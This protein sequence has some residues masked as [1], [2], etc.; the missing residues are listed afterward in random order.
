LRVDH[1]SSL[2]RSIARLDRDSYEARGAV[3]DRALRAL[4]KRIAVADPPYSQA[5]VDMEI[6]N[7]R[8]AI[9]RIE[10]GDMDD[11]ASL[12]PEYQPAPELSYLPAPVRLADAEPIQHELDPS[13][14]EEIAGK[15]RSIFGRVAGRSIIAALLIGAVIAGYSHVT[16][17]IDLSSL[18]GLMDRV[19]AINWSLSGDSA[20][21]GGLWRTDSMEVTQSAELLESAGGEPRGQP[22]AGKAVWRVLTDETGDTVLAL[23]VEIP[24]RGF[25]MAMTLRRDETVGAAMSHLCEI[26]FRGSDQFPVADI[27]QIVGVRMKNVGERNG[28]VLVGQV[29]RIAPDAFLF[30]LSALP[31]DMR[32]NIAAIR[33]RSRLELLVSLTDN[34]T[35]MLVVDKGESGARAFAEAF[36]KWGQ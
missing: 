17:Q 21:P 4:E 12:V 28:D 18:F 31:N 32:H 26:Q 6:L 10:F 9:R 19:T 23:D 36:N 8:D 33:G 16:G 22:S 7:F 2:A 29:V 30:G 20:A 27:T 34:R 13:V 14:A 3:Y 1:Y 15:R 35:A 25:A 5:D 24:E 11:N